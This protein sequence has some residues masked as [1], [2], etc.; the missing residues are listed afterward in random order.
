MNWNIIRS[1]FRCITTHFCGGDN[2]SISSLFI[3]SGKQKRAKTSERVFRTFSDPMTPVDLF[4]G[5]DVPEAL[6]PKD[7]IPAAGGV[8]YSSKVKLGRIINGPTGREPKY[9]PLLVISPSCHQ[10]AG[11]SGALSPPGCHRGPS[12]VP[13]CSY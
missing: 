6:Q 5:S 11:Q 12:L 2:N 10:T 1:Y 3:Q 7:V 13:G 4:T 8:P 9:V